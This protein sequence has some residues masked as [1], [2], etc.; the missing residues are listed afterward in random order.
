MRYTFSKSLC[1]VPIGVSSD[2]AVPGIMVEGA[3]IGVCMSLI[4]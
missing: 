4:V 2:I 3:S 1:L